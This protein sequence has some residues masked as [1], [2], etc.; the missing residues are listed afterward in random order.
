[1]IL[2][3]RLTLGLFLFATAL[4]CRA[5]STATVP[6]EGQQN[7]AALAEMD[8][9][10][11]SD[12]DYGVIDDICVRDICWV[13]VKG[14]PQKMAIFGTQVYHPI[15]YHLLSRRLV[16]R[17]GSE[18][19]VLD[20]GTGTGALS[21]LG[22][23]LGAKSA[24][25]TDINPISISNFRFNAERFGWSDRME[26]R[27]VSLDDTSAYSEIGPEER[28]DLI[29]SNPPIRDAEPKTIAD[30]AESDLGHQ[31]VVSMVRGLPQHLKAGGA[32]WLAYDAPAGIEAIQSVVKDA[33]L[34][35]RVYTYSGET[36]L[37]DYKPPRDPETST[38]LSGMGSL[39]EITLAAPQRGSDTA[40][41]TPE[42]TP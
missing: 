28:F 20:L 10:R 4:S 42:V 16:T 1:M 17:A 23:A 11:E 38:L 27:L 26:A 31:W 5:P 34:F 18:F 36:P 33:G 41:R 37:R 21:L 6:D 9:W 19:T 22:L 12:V 8:D 24:V 14:L 15:D 32:L 29:V 30:Y 2:A 35:G 3:S 39:V 25:G 13:P 40:P 7:D